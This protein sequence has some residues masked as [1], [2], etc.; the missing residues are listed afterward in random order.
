MRTSV[1]YRSTPVRRPRVAVRTATLPY[2][3][4]P[5]ASLPLMPHK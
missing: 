4:K 3:G 5:L 1:G 2:L